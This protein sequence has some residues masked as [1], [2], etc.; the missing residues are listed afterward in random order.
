MLN[1]DRP[2][3]GSSPVLH[4]SI[5]Q[6]CSGLLS[7]TSSFG[8]GPAQKTWQG[9]LG[10]AKDVRRVVKFRT[11]LRIGG[12]HLETKTYLPTRK[13][14]TPEGDR[15]QCRELSQLRRDET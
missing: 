4:F 10:S 13:V 1:P 11:R 5:R 2:L 12:V 3:F 9:K 6:R 7:A 14:I 8:M 15:L